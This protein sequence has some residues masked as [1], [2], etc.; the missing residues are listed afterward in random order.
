MYFNTCN[1]ALNFKN[2]YKTRYDFIEILKTV[3]KNNKNWYCCTFYWTFCIQ[4]VSK[5]FPLCI[6][7]S[8]KSF[9]IKM[10][11]VVFS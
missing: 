1:I 2:F 11:S 4:G 7:V 3:I 10:Y 9:L 8:F 6:F 5:I